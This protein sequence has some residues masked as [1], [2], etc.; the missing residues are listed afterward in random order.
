MEEGIPES[1]WEKW[2]SGCTPNEFVPNEKIIWDDLKNYQMQI[3]YPLGRGVSGSVFVVKILDSPKN[4]QVNNFLF[5]LKI[6]KTDAASVS[7]G[8]NEVLILNLSRRAFNV[9]KNIVFPSILTSFTVESRKAFLVEIGGPTLYQALALREY[10]GFPLAPVRS[11]ARQ[12]LLALADMENK[13]LVHGDIKPENI[14][15]SLRK[16]G[17]MKSFDNYKDDMSIVSRNII[18]DE[19]DSPSAVDMLL[20][21]WSSSSMG[22]RQPAEYMQSRYYRAPE[23]ILRASYGPSV[24]IWSLACVIVELVTGKPLFPGKDE[25]EMLLLIQQMFGSI[26]Q[27]LLKSIGSESICAKTDEW[28]DTTHIYS[29]SNFEQYIK[30]ATHRD[31]PEISLFIN[32]LRSLLHINPDARSSA[33]SAL[34]HPFISGN[35]NVRR[36][37][38]ESAIIPGYINPVIIPKQQSTKEQPHFI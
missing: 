38:R 16:F 6:F 36:R 21:D 27:A 3:I 19:F 26:P 25:I 34:M 32:F 22:Y 14:L 9:S 28:K 37:R 10:R 30:E 23:I 1:A 15:F 17:A 11:I 4:P 5:A 12:I 20:I 29:P 8:E 13:G 18:K 7:Q 2:I 24:D 33:S 31:D 35:M